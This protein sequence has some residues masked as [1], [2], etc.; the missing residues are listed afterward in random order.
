MYTNGCDV[1]GGQHPL[2]LVL[3]VVVSCPVFARTETGDLEEQP[4][5][6][7]TDTLLYP[8]PELVVLT[9]VSVLREE[10]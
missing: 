8:P 9:G 4:V 3:Q 7:T 5:L 6:L 10:R 2:K 1:F